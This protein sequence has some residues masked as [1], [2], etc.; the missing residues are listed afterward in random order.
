MLNDS[1]P[2]IQQQLKDGIAKGYWTLEN[3]DKPSAGWVANTFVDIRT[4]PDGYQ[5]IQHRNLL[6]D[7]MPQPERVQVIDPKDLPPM[8][9]GVT[10]AEATN[11]PSTLDNDDWF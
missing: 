6:R 9:Q 7:G 5:G 1:I 4:F 8:A 11:L 10:P 3:L 2:A